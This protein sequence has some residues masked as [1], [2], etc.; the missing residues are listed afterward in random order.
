MERVV[1]LLHFSEYYHHARHYIGYTTSLDERLDAHNGG[2]GAKLI[3]AIREKGLS[4][5]VVRVWENGSRKLE[6]QLKR[7]KNSKRFCPICSKHIKLDKGIR[8][9]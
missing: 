2:T 8:D 9:E 3:K 6:R 7:Q 5:E 4:F 1:Y